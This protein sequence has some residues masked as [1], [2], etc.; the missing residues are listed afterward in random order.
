[1]GNYSVVEQPSGLQSE[2]V[3]LARKSCHRCLLL[4]YPG[5]L[6]RFQ[7]IVALSPFQ[8]RHIRWRGWG[9]HSRTATLAAVYPGLAASHSPLSEAWRPDIV[10]FVEQPSSVE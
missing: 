6:A 7:P 3:L 5:L 8:A 4:Q 9:V 1:M 2:N 10:L